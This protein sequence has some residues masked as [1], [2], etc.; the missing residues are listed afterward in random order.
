[1]K[2]IENIPCNI[3][4]F[5]FDKK[6]SFYNTTSTRD[7]YN[8]STNIYGKILILRYV[9]SQFPAWDAKLDKASILSKNRF[10]FSL[11]FGYYDLGVH[12]FD[13]FW[14]VLTAVELNN[15]SNQGNF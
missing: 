5:Y 6:N 9:Y 15:L 8:R 11:I 2:G 14:L 10:Q 3:V 4:L 1:M 7:L 13:S 12:S